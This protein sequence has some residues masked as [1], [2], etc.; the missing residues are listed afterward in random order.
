MNWLF[1]Q[2]ISLIVIGLAI[3]FLLGVAWVQTGK[4]VFLYAMAVAVLLFGVLLV[5]ERSV[6]TDREAVEARVYQL[7]EL[8]EQ[9]KVDEIV[10]SF[11]VSRPEWAAKAR[12][13]LP[14]YQ[15]TEAR[16][17]Q[18]HRV[19]V[20]SHHQPPEVIVEL[21]VSVSG[22]FEQFA[23]GTYLRWLRV[24]FWKEDDGQWRVAD[25]EHADPVKFM[26]KAD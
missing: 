26:R 4:N 6:V 9:N 23:T 20:N 10:K 12:Q 11:V 24:K 18:I 8:V 13:E 3:A 1:D 22:T 2:P 19:E 16:V 25:Y 15:F 14:R 7:A 17:T 5:V 21:N